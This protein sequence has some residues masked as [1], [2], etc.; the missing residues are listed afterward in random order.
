MSTGP[1]PR[2]RRKTQ[3]KTK[4]QLNTYPNVFSVPA[5]K[6]GASKAYDA[7]A[8]LEEKIEKLEKNRKT[9]RLIWIISLILV[10][11]LFSYKSLINS[12]PVFTLI[13]FIEIVFLCI[14]GKHLENE[15]MVILCEKILSYLCK[16]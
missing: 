3:S 10:A 13:F 6:A 12:A 14:I 7:T 4:P 9:E 15:Y 8:E 16:K 2:R 1:A 5:Q 11:D